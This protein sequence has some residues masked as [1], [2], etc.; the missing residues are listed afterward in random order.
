MRKSLILVM[1]VAVLW[2]GS[3]AEAEEL[4]NG[5]LDQTYAQEI[6]PGFFAPK[7]LGWQN[8]GT[9]AITGP[10][11]D[12]MSSEPWAG[13][14]P[15]PVTADGS[16]DPYPQSCGG[17]D[18]AAFFKA[19]SGSA[20][21]GPATGHL[22]Q[23]VPATTGR[24]YTMTAWAG[25][26]AN[27]MAERFEFALEFLDAGNSIL[28][29]SA[30]DLAVAGLLVPN[31][32]PFNYKQYTLTGVAPVGTVSARVRASFINGT[33]NPAGGGQAFVV[34]DFS[35]TSIPEPAS[36]MALL[37]LG[38]LWATRRSRRSARNTC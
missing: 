37:G 23:D 22:Y 16:L 1:G 35:L 17:M 29:A 36:A 3:L 10:Y 12:E 14:A 20:S 34:D 9:R 15:T 5:N 31:G 32:Q 26:E 24:T 19:F 7:P 13:P 30:L 8:V 27:V 33:A 18:C 21:N 28:S 4:F 11:E 6:V 2:A 38:T 25:G